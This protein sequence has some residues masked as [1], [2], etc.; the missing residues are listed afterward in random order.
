M[1]RATTR[2]AACSTSTRGSIVEEVRGG[3]GREPFVHGGFA[4]ED[5]AF[6]DGVRDGR[7][8]GPDLAASRQSLELAEVL[9]ARRE[10]FVA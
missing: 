7:P 2:R 9:R 3:R 8:L 4:A 10:E 6:L 5:A 1:E